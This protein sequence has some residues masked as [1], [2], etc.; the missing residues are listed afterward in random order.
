MES[1]VE[2]ALWELMYI[3][4][5][6]PWSPMAPPAEEEDRYIAGGPSARPRGSSRGAQP[7]LTD[8]SIGERFAR[9][10]GPRLQV[11]LDHEHHAAPIEGIGQQMSRDLPFWASLENARRLWATVVRLGTWNEH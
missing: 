2:D 9:L 5:A 7:P 6:R 10:A 1:H 8:A 11:D 3:G 4:R